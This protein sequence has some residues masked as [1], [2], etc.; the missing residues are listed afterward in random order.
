MQRL[1]MR[2]TEQTA[3]SEMYYVSV[4]GS[5]PGD[6]DDNQILFFDKTL[7]TRKRAVS[8]ELVHF[9]PIHSLLRSLHGHRRIYHSRRHLHFYYYLSLI[10]I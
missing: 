9:H 10:H 1:S 7:F 3:L 8:T 6:K 5:A 2:K 4:S